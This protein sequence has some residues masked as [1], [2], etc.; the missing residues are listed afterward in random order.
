DPRSTIHDPRSAIRDPR[1]GQIQKNQT[2]R[3][4]SKIP[5]SNIDFFAQINHSPKGLFSG[6]V[7]RGT[8]GKTVLSLR[9]VLI[10]GW[11]YSEVSC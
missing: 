1:F 11:R 3:L 4:L 8:S 6:Y 10:S 9:V 5:Y 2:D 7:L